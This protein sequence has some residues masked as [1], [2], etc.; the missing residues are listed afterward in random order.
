MK[1]LA[2]DIGN[3]LCDISMDN[4]LH[5]LCKETGI[6]LEEGQRF[7]KK[8][9]KLHDLGHA[10]IHDNLKDIF[11]LKAP[12]IINKLLDHW[13]ND[14]VFANQKMIEKITNLKNT[15]NVKIAL[16][17]NIGIEHAEII[18]EKLNYNNFYQDSVKY[19]SCFVGARKP[20]SIYY[21]SFILQHPEFKG[22]TYVDDLQE[23]LDASMHFGFNPFRFALDEHNIDDKILE[24]EEHICK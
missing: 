8:T 15:Y 12:I 20:T 10:T 4:F 2:I 3:V 9:Q 18:K 24:L 6:S 7:L 16:L 19:F 1:F 5:P 17:S 14:V 21:H 11:N 22:C 13:N 23:N